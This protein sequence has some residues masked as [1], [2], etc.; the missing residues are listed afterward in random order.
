MTLVN[1]VYEQQSCPSR[2]HK[3]VITMQFPVLN[4]RSLL[5]LISHMP[6]MLL[7]EG[8]G[9]ETNNQF[10][11]AL[12]ILTQQRCAEKFQQPAGRNLL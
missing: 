10:G 4:S 11:V 8:E 2:P 3:L 9:P 7:P 12:P 6:H 1:Y 5:V